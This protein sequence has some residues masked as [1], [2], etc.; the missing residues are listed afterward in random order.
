MGVSVVLRVGAFE[1]VA[2]C[3]ALVL[4]DRLPDDVGVTTWVD[5][6]V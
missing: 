1:G 5:V 3:V 2:V 4:C 6:I